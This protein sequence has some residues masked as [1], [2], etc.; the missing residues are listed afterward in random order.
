VSHNPFVDVLAVGTD[1]GAI[2]LVDE[3]TLQ[4]VSLLQRSMDSTKVQNQD[5]EWH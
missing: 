4:V 1:S 5:A 2:K 3:R